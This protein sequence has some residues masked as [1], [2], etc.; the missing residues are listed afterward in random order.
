[1]NKILIFIGGV[2]AGIVLV[3]IVA[4]IMTH[5]NSSNNGMQ[6]FEEVGECVSE[7]SFEVLQVLDSGDA[8]AKEVKHGVSIGLT[9]LFLNEDDQ[10]YYDDQIIEMPSGMCAKQ[11]GVFKYIAKSGLEKTVPVV[12]IRDK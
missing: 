9:V 4:F 6:L 3:I 10:A 5:E 7:N 11:V 8:L 2:I 12:I 1:M